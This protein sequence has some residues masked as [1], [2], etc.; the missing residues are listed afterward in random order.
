MTVRARYQMAMWRLI[1]HRDVLTFTGACRTP[2]CGQ[3]STPRTSPQEAQEWCLG[4]AGLTGHRHYDLTTTQ[5]F[6]ATPDG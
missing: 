1:G 4:H 3:D 2:E 6:T 5:M